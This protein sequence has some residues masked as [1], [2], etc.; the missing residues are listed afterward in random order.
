MVIITVPPTVE[1]SI[2]I[3]IVNPIVLDFALKA[4]LNVNYWYIWSS[5]RLD[6]SWSNFRPK[7]LLHDT[8]WLVCNGCNGWMSCKNIVES[9]VD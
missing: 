9:V 3:S 1:A 6:T 5:R 4:P 8:V 2:R 7:E